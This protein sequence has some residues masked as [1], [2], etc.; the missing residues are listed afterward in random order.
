MNHAKDT[1]TFEASPYVI[2]ALVET[3]FERASV[4][5]ERAALMGWSKEECD[6]SIQLATDLAFSLRGQAAKYGHVF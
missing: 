1:Y 5:K 2:G 4:M 3:L 6:D